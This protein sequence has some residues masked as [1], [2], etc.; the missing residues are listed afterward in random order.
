MIVSHHINSNNSCYTTANPLVRC[1]CLHL[2]FQSECT[3]HNTTC[4]C[5]DVGPCEDYNYDLAFR[6]IIH[7]M[8][9]QGLHNHTYYITVNATNN[10]GLRTT[11]VIDILIDISPP[12]VGVVLENV[13]ETVSG[14]ANFTSH[15]VIHVRWHGFHDEESGV[16]LYRVVLAD[17]CLTIEEMERADH[18]TEISD[19]QSVTLTFP[20][21]GMCR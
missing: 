14:E 13:R 3:S 4:Y 6:Q 18:V 5:P 9:S 15:D 17:R 20:A 11:K 8:S 2:F 12:S 21:E 10:A 1:S 19:G 16:M 7:P